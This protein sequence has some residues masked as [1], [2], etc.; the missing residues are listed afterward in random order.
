MHDLLLSFGS[1]TFLLHESELVDILWIDFLVIAALA[2]LL[3]LLRLA[4]HEDALHGFQFVSGFFVLIAK[5]SH[6][7][8]L[9]DGTGLVEIGGQVLSEGFT[10]HRQFKKSA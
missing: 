5:Y 6:Q 10:R 8:A 1:L 7:V 2:L 4:N 9:S 3:L